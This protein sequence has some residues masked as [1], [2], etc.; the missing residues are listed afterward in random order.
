M[1]ILFMG[2]PD[3]AL[4]CLQ[5][6]VNAGEEIVG[7][8][9]Q[10]D[11]PKGR[12]YALVAP[13]VKEYAL[14]M[15]FPVYQPESLKDEEFMSVLRTLDPELIAVVAYGRILPGQVLDY[16]KYGCVNVH[17]SILPLYRGA[18]PM[19]RAIMDGHTETGVTTMYMERG[20]DTGDILEMRITP[21]G[22]DDNFEDIHDRL[23]EMGAELLPHTVAGLAAGTIV[24]T[25]QDGERACY[26]EKIT[27]EDCVIDFT[28]SAKQVH[29]RIRG[30]SPI[31][32]AFTK[33]SGKLL[34]AVRSQ[35]VKSEGNYGTPGQVIDLSD[36]RIHVACGEG[37][38][39][40][41]QVRPEGKGSMSS[42]D[43]I[44]GRKI[45]VGDL[46]GE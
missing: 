42:A 45:A 10:P 13:P 36:G 2:T 12:G 4:T 25:P 5:G 15:G 28:E 40:L 39:A 19:Q 33:L 27:K 8:V 37:V 29:D 23:A 34:K 11:R 30:L 26:A 32:L 16:P 14:E 3:F 22:E 46:L 17:S 6:L 38:I 31:P 1:R 44:R 41:T 9:T 24:P 43:Y 21:I 7:V 20:L 35:I 18:A